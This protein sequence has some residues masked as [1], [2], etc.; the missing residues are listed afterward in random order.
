MVLGEKARDTPYEVVITV[1]VEGYEPIQFSLAKMCGKNHRA[2]IQKNKT[3][4][5]SL[6][7]MHA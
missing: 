3:V 6:S 4:P 7:L 1:P 5:L 2:I